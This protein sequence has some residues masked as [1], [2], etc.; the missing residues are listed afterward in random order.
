[1]TSDGNLY[2]LQYGSY[3]SKDV[4]EENVKK[5][6]NYLVYEEDMKYYVFLG[7]YTDLSIAQKV[8]KIFENQG[9]YTYIKND[10]LGNSEVIK[11][12]SELEKNIFEEEDNV[13]ISAINNKILDILKNI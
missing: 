9:L 11:R 6:N 5:L 13:K 4:M 7:A 8:S 12:I 1:M 10:Y 2:M 3:I